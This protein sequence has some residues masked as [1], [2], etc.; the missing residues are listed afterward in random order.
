M[1]AKDSTTAAMWSRRLKRDLNWT[2]KEAKIVVMSRSLR[3][4]GLHNM[5]G[6]AG[7]CR[8]DS[9]QPWFKCALAGYS[10]DDIEAG[11]ILYLRLGAG[12]LKN[13]TELTQ[14][15]VFAKAVHFAT[16]H[17]VGKSF[18]EPCL[19]D[20]LSAMLRTGLFYPSANFVMPSGGRGMD[21]ERAEC[22]FGALMDPEGVTAAMVERVFY[23]PC[24]DK[25]AQRYWRPAPAF[26]RDLD[27]TADQLREQLGDVE[28]DSPVVQQLY[29]SMHTHGPESFHAWP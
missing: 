22:L 23:A 14:K 5:E 24:S 20:V 6:M 26:L 12:P 4:T 9:H 3:M 19:V 17:G 25:D 28:F 21:G 13:K 16:F 2:V 7:Y 29:A 18:R 10:D 27:C 15:N 1:E 11:D 8:K